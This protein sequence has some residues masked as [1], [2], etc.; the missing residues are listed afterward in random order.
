[1]RY[2]RL[3][4]TPT[5]KF[6]HIFDAP[7][8]NNVLPVA[9]DQIEITYVSVGK[10]L[11]EQGWERIESAPFAVGCNLFDAPANISA[12]D[13]H[14]H[15]TVC[16]KVPFVLLAEDEEGA[17]CLPYRLSLDKRE[18]IHDLIDE[19][20]RLY[21]LE[22][23]KQWGLTGLFLQLLEE[24]SHLARRQFDKSF[25]AYSPY[26]NRA[27]EYICQ[28]LQRPISEKEVAA[29]LGITPEYLCA[30]FKRANDVSLITFAN[31]AKLVRIRTE[32]EQENLRLYEAA[33]RY[34]YNDPNYVSRL[35]KRYFGKNI[36]DFKKEN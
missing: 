24:Y 35:Y 19:I 25:P 23:E 36:T 29:H 5:I 4:G 6:A 9:K 15:R 27:K 10:T 8:Y 3:C 11:R 31:Q 18:K 20:I 28:N 7:S 33:A 32:M 1:M 22:P 12:K 34:G 16:F 2:I 14:V 30:V 21:M 26:V 17:F 13:Y